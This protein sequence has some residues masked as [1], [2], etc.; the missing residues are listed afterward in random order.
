MYSYRNK[1]ICAQFR[2][3]Y[4]YATLEQILLTSLEMWLMINI[5]LFPFTPL[6]QAANSQHP[7]ETEQLGNNPFT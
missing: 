7:R 1:Y 5:L 2:Y 3:I 4:I 6:D